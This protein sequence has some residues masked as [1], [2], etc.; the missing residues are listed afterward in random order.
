M[1]VRDPEVRRLI[2]GDV[3][4]RGAPE[5]IGDKIRPAR[6]AIGGLRITAD[7]VAVAPTHSGELVGV[8]AHCQNVRIAADDNPPSAR[9]SHDGGARIQNVDN[10]RQCRAREN[11]CG[12]CRGGRR[13]RSKSRP[14]SQ[15]Q[16]SEASNAT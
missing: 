13:P 7:E 4:F 10:H 12:G 5:M 11:R 15:R 3:G 6:R 16:T 14:R 1:S 9:V 8:L 2:G